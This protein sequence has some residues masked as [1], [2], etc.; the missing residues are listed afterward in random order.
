M[1]FDHRLDWDV[2]GRRLD[3]Q[4]VGDDGAID[5]SGQLVELLI[6]GGD[7][8]EHLGVGQET[9]LDRGGLELVAEVTDKE[10]DLQDSVLLLRKR[11]TNGTIPVPTRNDDSTYLDLRDFRFPNKPSIELRILFAYGEQI[12]GTFFYNIQ[13]SVDRGVTYTLIVSDRAKNKSKSVETKMITL[14]KV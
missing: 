12:P 3:C 2:S 1:P 8:R 11:F 14:K 13:E 4:A 9:S 5:D 6:D 10:G 7:R